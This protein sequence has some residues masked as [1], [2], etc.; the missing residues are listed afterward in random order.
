MDQKLPLKVNL[1]EALQQPQFLVDDF[2]FSLE[3]LSLFRI[4]W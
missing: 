1:I 3:E 2:Q 4:R